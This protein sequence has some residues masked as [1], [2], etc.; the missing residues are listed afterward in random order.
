VARL[1][2]YPDHIL[3]PLS[4]QL[5][6]ETLPE[7]EGWVDRPRLLDI[8]GRNRKRQI[9]LAARFALSDYPKPAGGC[10]LT[11]PNFSK[12]LRDLLRDIPDPRPRDLEL[13]KLGRHIRWGEHCRIIV[14]R[15]EQENNRLE[16]LWEEGDYRLWVNGFPGPV[17]ILASDA[18]AP[19][20]ALLFAAQVAAR[21]SDAPADTLTE[22]AYTDG[23]THGILR[24]GTC[25]EEEIR[26]RLL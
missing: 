13:L 16:A 6:P 18:P 21:Y 19:N 20:E 8:Q 26:K 12:R 3:R 24:A 11:E 17:V 15:R 25:E 7:Q 22:V 2:G 4:A 23:K 10:L 14:G 5:L 9:E 1:S